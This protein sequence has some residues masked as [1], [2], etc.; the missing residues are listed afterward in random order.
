MV[1]PQSHH[2]DSCAHTLFTVQGP[3]RL[4]LTL[5]HRAYRYAVEIEADVWDFAVEIHELRRAGLTNSEFRWLLA[6]HYVNHAEE[7]T[8]AGD[9]QRAF[10]PLGKHAFPDR[11]CFVLTEAG[12]A[13][14]GFTFELSPHPP[15]H[16]GN[17]KP[18]SDTFPEDLP[19]NG[20]LDP[21]STNRQPHWDA[22]RKELRVGT[23]VVKVLKWPAP[24]Q[25]TVLAVFEEEGWPARIDD[26]L[27]GV[28]EQD[29]KRRLH[30]TIKC[31]NRSHKAKVI[32]FRGDGTGEGVIW[33]Y[34]NE[35]DPSK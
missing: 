6:C 2:G 10:R 4:A 23:K 29:P 7:I 14:S 27:P 15:L 5:L 26:P 31:L 11:T 17:G 8:E 30:D 13:A 12:A 21:P 22:E 33:T 25:E 19:S 35:A 16:E 1:R 32:H 24:N 3:I 28:A 18:A 20:R 34:V 9:E